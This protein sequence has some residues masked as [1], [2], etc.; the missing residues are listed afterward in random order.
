VADDYYTFEKELNAFLDPFI[1]PEVG[2][3][4][5]DPSVSKIIGGVTDAFGRFGGDPNFGMNLATYASELAPS[6]YNIMD[7]EDSAKFALHGSSSLNPVTW[8]I[9]RTA[10]NV[11]GKDYL[12]KAGLEEAPEHLPGL[13]DVLRGYQTEKGWL[14]GET[15]HPISLT[16]DMPTGTGETINTSLLGILNNQIGNISAHGGQPLHHIGGLL[17]IADDLSGDPV[18]DLGEVLGKYADWIGRGAESEHMEAESEHME[19][20]E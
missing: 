14:G 8:G 12:E 15:Q 6:P 4:A 18:E 13:V 5:V 10:A 2:G 20:E 16:F 11:L 9:L 17:D 1:N 3:M 7:A 19:K